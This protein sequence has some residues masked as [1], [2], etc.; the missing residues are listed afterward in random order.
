[1]YQ[2]RVVVSIHPAAGATKAGLIRG[3]DV[4]YSL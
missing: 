4:L 3:G 2:C 1:L